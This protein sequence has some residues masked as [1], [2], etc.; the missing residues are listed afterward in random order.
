MP[1]DIGLPNPPS[2]NGFAIHNIHWLKE[3]GLIT[4]DVGE[5][6]DEIFLPIMGSL[7]CLKDRH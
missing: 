3:S 6:V 4:A 2:V 1:A 5:G 7:G